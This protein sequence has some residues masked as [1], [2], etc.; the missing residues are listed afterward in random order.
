MLMSKQMYVIRISA[1][2]TT[3]TIMENFDSS[4]R[5]SPFL[6]H[7]KEEVAWRKLDVQFF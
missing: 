1:R 5:A 2:N 6:L 4:R 3:I 7:L